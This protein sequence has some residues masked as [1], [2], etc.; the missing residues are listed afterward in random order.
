MSCP[1]KY[2]SIYP[3]LQSVLPRTADDCFDE[4]IRLPVHPDSHS[5]EYWRHSSFLLYHTST[6]VKSV[7][8]Y[9]CVGIHC[10]DNKYRNTDGGK[11][12]QIMEWLSAHILNMCCIYFG[13]TTSVIV[14]LTGLKLLCAHPNHREQSIY[15]MLSQMRLFKYFRINKMF[16]AWRAN[17]RHKLF[18]DV[19][20]KSQIT[21]FLLYVLIAGRHVCLIYIARC[22][23]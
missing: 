14:Y 23:G 9:L 16:R 2:Y 12:V 4:Q 1:Y 7:G 21:I 18:C 22:I 19:S 11:D 10:Q 3:I 5:C 20:T 8:T 17:I 15:K 13:T 6:T